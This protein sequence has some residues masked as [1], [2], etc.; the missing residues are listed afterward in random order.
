VIRAIQPSPVEAADMRIHILQERAFV[1]KNA[2][3]RLTEIGN[4]LI[5]RLETLSR[6]VTET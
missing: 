5:K 2:N 4:I 6:F 1:V 3:S